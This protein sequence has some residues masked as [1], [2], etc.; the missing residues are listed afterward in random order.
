[1]YAVLWQAL[2]GPWW[3]PVALLLLLAAAV[4]VICFTVVFPEIAPL[5]PFKRR[6][7]GGRTSRARARWLT[8]YLRRAYAASAPHSRSPVRTR[9]CPATVKPSLV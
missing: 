8:T 2:P 9:H 6:H 7:R 5:L 1:M 3:V 4:V